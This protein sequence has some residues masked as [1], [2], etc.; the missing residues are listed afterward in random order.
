MLSVVINVC[1]VPKADATKCFGRL[2]LI[3]PVPR[4][5]EAGMT[6]LTGVDPAV[7]A[8]SV[9]GLLMRSGRPRGDG[10][11]KT[12]KVE[13][14]SGEVMTF[15][16]LASNPL[17]S[18]MLL[19]SG[20]GSPTASC[21][22]LSVTAIMTITLSAPSTA[23]HGQASCSRRSSSTKTP[24][25]L[26]EQ[27]TKGAWLPLKA[28]PSAAGDAAPPRFALRKNARKGR[29]FGG[30]IRFTCIKAKTLVFLY[31]SKRLGAPRPKTEGAA[32]V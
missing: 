31:W 27:I 18:P 16:M 21:S 19:G 22:T 15:T 4:A 29:L 28:R 10:L 12:M 3:E 17:A 25:A 26:R 6:E 8:D 9:L 2:T 32:F 11:G 7:L 1:L 14:E 23:R 20:F 13:Q 24:R 5:Y 30:G